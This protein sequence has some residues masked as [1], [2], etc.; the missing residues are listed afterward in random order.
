MR[1]A[2][3]PAETTITPRPAALF[4]FSGEGWFSTTSKRVSRGTVPG[5]VSSIIT[6][7]A[8]TNIGAQNRED[9][10]STILLETRDYVK[11]FLP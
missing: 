2:K 4:T 3:A 11:Y 5:F 7:S 10:L 9:F 6:T 8:P 1:A